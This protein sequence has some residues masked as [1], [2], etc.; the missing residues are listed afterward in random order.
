MIVMGI[1]I[2]GTKLRMAIMK[3]PAEILYR[4]EVLLTKLGVPFTLEAL[5]GFITK[6]CSEAHIPWT[7]I[8]AIGISVAAVV[9]TERGVVERG[10]NVGWE[11]LPVKEVL[12]ESLQ[13]PVVV[14]TDV[15]CGAIAE[16]CLGGINEFNNF[17]YV[18]VGTGIGHALVMQGEILRGAHQAASAFGHLKVVLGGAKC[19]CGQKG[20]L[21]Q[22][23]SGEGLLRLGREVLNSDRLLTVEDIIRSYTYGEAWAKKVIEEATTALAFSLSQAYTLFDMEGI[24][25]GGGVVSEIYPNLEQLTVLLEQMVYPQVR[26]IILRRAK[27]KTDSQ[28]FG[29]AY[30][31][32]QYLE[33]MKNG[34]KEFEDDY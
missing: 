34:W 19:Y 26:P 16:N 17:L 1:D 20:C 11:N 18:A 22:Y 21:C 30:F 5:I 12:E 32:F 31:A 10:E 14:N 24:V 6:Q 28:L 7:A 29:A 25:L 3:E 13:V 27:L 33:E 8:Q 9:D 2:G 15:F 4:S 23:S